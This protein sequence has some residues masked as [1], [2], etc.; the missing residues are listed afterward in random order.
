ME[1][2]RTM[3]EEEFESDG[4]EGLPDYVDEKGFCKYCK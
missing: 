2:I 3:E 4:D 1:I